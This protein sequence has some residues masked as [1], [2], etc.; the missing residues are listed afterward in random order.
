MILCY[1]YCNQFNVFN[2][3]RKKMIVMTEKV[4]LK[5]FSETLDEIIYIYILD[6]KKKKPQDRD[7]FYHILRNHSRQLILD[8]Y[9]AFEEMFTKNNMNQNLE[10]I[11]S[12]SL[13]Q[14]YPSFYLQQKC[15]A[16]AA[17]KHKKYSRKAI[18][19]SADYGFYSRS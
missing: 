9:D 18:R 3:I 1:D 10:V 5:E 14:S 8:Y 11:K 17:D 13:N 15:F 19:V 7:S 16:I 6:I 4:F 2:Q 12:A